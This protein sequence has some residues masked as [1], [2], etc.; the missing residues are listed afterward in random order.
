MIGVWLC[1]SMFK[2]YIRC[3][4]IE[5]FTTLSDYRLQESRLNGSSLSG[6]D[7]MNA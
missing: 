2:L 3:T 6:K 4:I 7:E 5:I 1:L